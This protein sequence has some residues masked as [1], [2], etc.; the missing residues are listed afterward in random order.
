[1]AFPRLSPLPLPLPLP[2]LSLAGPSQR[3]LRQSLDPVILSRG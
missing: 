2:P 3:R 1:M